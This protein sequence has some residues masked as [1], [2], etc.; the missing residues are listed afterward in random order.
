LILYAKLDRALAHF[1]MPATI[2]EPICVGTRAFGRF[3]PATSLD[4]ASPIADA[5]PLKLT[6]K[7]LERK[8]SHA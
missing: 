7:Y 1:V 3:L 5:A 2:T 4:S 8:I 6:G